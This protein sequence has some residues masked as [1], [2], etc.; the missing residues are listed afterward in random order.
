MLRA[1]ILIVVGIVLLITIV[2]QIVLPMF[3][4]TLSFFWYFRKGSRDDI[5][6]QTGEDTA[7]DNLQKQAHETSKQYKSV[8][9]VIKEQKNKLDKLD[10]ETDL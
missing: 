5:I 9:R 6:I 1:M 3:I 4:D 8:K 2:T 7:Y 10:K